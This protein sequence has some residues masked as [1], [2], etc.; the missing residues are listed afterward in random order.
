M[1]HHSSGSGMDAA[2]SVW[3]VARSNP[4]NWTGRSFIVWFFRAF[5][6]R[7]S[8]SMLWRRLDSRKCTCSESG[9]CVSMLLIVSDVF[10]EHLPLPWYR[11]VLM[12]KWK[13]FPETLQIRTRM[14]VSKGT[15]SNFVEIFQNFWIGYIWYLFCYRG[16]TTQ[17]K[18]SSHLDV[19]HCC[20]AP[21]PR[22]I[23]GSAVWKGLVSVNLEV[24][25]RCFE[26]LADMAGMV[27]GVW[28]VNKIQATYHVML[29]ISC[30]WLT[31]HA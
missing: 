21:C 23:C 17:S 15:T 5:H 18:R 14:R 6:F 30:S 12:R 20:Q 24:Y 4:M 2:R 7:S 22:R 19:F 8:P 28:Q 31:S 1:G 9:E 13:D 16:E 27:L 3:Q 25:P 11:S 10:P 26:Y 29:W